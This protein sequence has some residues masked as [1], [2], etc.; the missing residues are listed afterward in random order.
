MS[1]RLFML[2]VLAISPQLL[3]AETVPTMESAQSDYNAGKYTQA[4][5][6]YQ[7]IIDS[8]TIKGKSNS[9]NQELI[10][11]QYNLARCL[12]KAKQFDKAKEV[13]IAIAGS[14]DNKM[15]LRAKYDLGCLYAQIVN[16]EAGADPNQAEESVRKMI[17]SN[18]NSA[19]EQ[20]RAVLEIQPDYPDAAEKMERILTVLMDWESAW[21][22]ADLKKD[23][24]KKTALQYV[25]DVEN[26]IFETK[27]KSSRLGLKAD[28]LETRQEFF[29]TAEQLS[30]TVKKVGLLPDKAIKAM[31]G[32]EAV[33]EQGQP[34][35]PTAPPELTPEQEAQLEA[36]KVQIEQLIKDSQETLE[37]SA[38]E[39][40]ALDSKAS[41]A[42]QLKAY[43]T[44]DGFYL[45][46]SPLHEMIARSIK[47]QKDLIKVTEKK[48]K[49]NQKTSKK[50]SKQDAEK[51]ENQSANPSDDKLSQI[52]LEENV[53]KQSALLPLTQAIV[54]KAKVMLQQLPP[55]KAAPN[56][57]DNSTLKENA[58]NLQDALDAL[59]NPDDAAIDPNSANPQDQQV[60]KIRNMCKKA[61]ELGP[62][63]PPLV[64]SAA[65][66][67]NASKLESALESQK[68]ALRLL[69]EIIKDDSQQNKDNQDQ[70][71][72][73]QQNQDKQNQDKQN[74][75]KQN[76]D[77]QNQD[78]QNQNKDQQNQDKQDQDKQD[79]QDQDKQDQDKQDEQNKDE[80]DKDEQDKKS[81]EEEQK[82]Q[83]EKDAQQDEQDAQQQEGQEQE[84]QQKEGELT[85]AQERGLMRRVQARQEEQKKLEAKLRALLNPPDKVEKDW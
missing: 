45:A 74:Q 44:L 35:Q 4:A 80:Q 46:L 36:A 67:L 85:D 73:D 22:D 9:S 69:E 61:V 25:V 58:E 47:E 49:K 57:G 60:Q 24:E 53:F 78:K 71:N 64:Q 84:A 34:V 52:E 68:E 54:P 18:V 70:Q 62:K 76:Q 26:E 63:I 6:K 38:K 7:K 50:E 37:E 10:I 30:D 42:S 77:K 23:A 17:R 29:Q 3:L 14:T 65:D 55:E 12:D 83:D 19:V 15:A 72:Q 43:Q 28:S 48:I 1:I 51:T 16:L 56:G 20:W 40:C 75:D 82:D 11:C 32:Q 59:Q 31:T 2:F 27:K 39:L 5:D 33:G 8:L 66:D 21:K 41:S 79:Q 13:Y 81:E